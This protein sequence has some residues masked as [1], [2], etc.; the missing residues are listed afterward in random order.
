MKHLEGLLKASQ[1]V[2]G[3]CVVDFF[4]SSQI[5]LVS[6]GNQSEID[7]MFTV[8]KNLPEAVTSCASQHDL[9]RTR[10]LCSDCAQI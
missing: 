1:Y 2:L 3:T 5:I 4:S 10:Y 8:S 9:L 6:N 7:G